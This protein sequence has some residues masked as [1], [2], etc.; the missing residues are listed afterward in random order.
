MLYTITHLRG[1]LHITMRDLR[2][3]LAFMM[4]GTRD[5]DGIHQL[6]QN[7]GEENQNRI[8]DGFYFNS[9]LGGSKRSNDRLISLLHEI[10]V[11]QVSNP[12]LD[13]ELGFLNPK[14]KA[15]SRFSFSERAGY[16]EELFD[17][18]FNNLPRDYSQK[19]RARLIGKHR[20][21]LSHMRRRHFFERRDKGWKEMLPYRSIDTFLESIEQPGAKNRKEVTSILRAINRGEGLADPMR[22]GNQLALRVRHVDRGTIR[23]FRLFDGEHFTLR[24]ELEAAYNPFLECLSQ[25]IVLIYN[26]GNG[27]KASLRINLDIYEMLMRLNSGYRPSIEEQEGFYLSLAVFKNVLSAA[28]YQEVLLTS[29]GYEFFQIRRDD[30]GILHMEK[31]DRRVET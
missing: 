13:R 31:L 24:T 19:N 25:A 14:T 1:R 10:D 11:A 27:H 16:D 12:D 8:L 28:P 30:R 2:S 7:G 22:L 4:V 20:N 23:S 6:Y 21:Y 5:C 18:L 3:A 17:M 26:S 9:W 29:S 15:M